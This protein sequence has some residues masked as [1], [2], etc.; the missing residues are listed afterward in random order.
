MNPKVQGCHSLP[1]DDIDNTVVYNAVS[2][3]ALAA[4]TTISVYC[5][6]FIEYR[7]TSA[8]LDL[9]TPYGLYSP[10]NTRIP[11]WAGNTGK[12][13]LVLWKIY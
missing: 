8:E 6:Q 11:Y 2:K 7:C 9:S 12:Y 10:K 4:L 1:T 5:T 13:K 3:A